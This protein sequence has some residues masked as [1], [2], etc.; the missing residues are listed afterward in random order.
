MTSPFS[1]SKTTPAKRLKLFLWGNSGSGK[2]TLALRFP[3]PV[4]IDLEKGTDHYRQDFEFEF[5]QT[6]DWYEVLKAV[7]HL[8]ANPGQFDTLVIDPISELWQSCQR[9]WEQ[10]FLMERKKGSPNHH[11]DWYEFSIGDWG[12]IKKEWKGFISRLISLDMN[13]VAIARAKPDYDRG[14]GKLGDTWD[15][16]RDTAYPFDVQVQ[17]ELIGDVRKATVHKDR[18]NKLPHRF[19]LDFEVF[20]KAFSNVLVSQVTY[21]DAKMVEAINVFLDAEGDKRD[22]MVKAI[23]AKF[24]VPKLENLKAEEADA[25]L[26]RL[27][28]RANAREKSNAAN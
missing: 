25:L 15:C 22:E 8:E 2:T 27:A 4:V 10:R 18:L 12:P 19:D 21:A 7:A 24:K 17:L 11:G 14:G 1:H 23:L 3:N 13:V 6:T 9:A 16:E 28:E 26:S 5:R 20:A